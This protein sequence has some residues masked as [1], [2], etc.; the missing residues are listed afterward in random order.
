MRRLIA[1]LIFLMVFVSLAQ[2]RTYGQSNA[3]KG[4]FIKSLRARH[5]DS[6]SL[7][8]QIHEKTFQDISD[9]FQKSTST[10]LRPCEG[11]LTFL[12][13]G[14][15]HVLLDVDFMRWDAKTEAM[16]SRSNQ[17]LFKEGRLTEYIRHARHLATIAKK[18]PQISRSMYVEAIAALYFPLESPDFYSIESL[19]FSHK[20]STGIHVFHGNGI[21][22]WSN[23]QLGWAPVEIRK[24]GGGRVRIIYKLA[25]SALTEDAI[26]RLASWSAEVLGSDAKPV[27]GFE[28]EVTG[29]ELNPNLDDSSFSIQFSP[30]TVVKDQIKRANSVVMDDFSLRPYISE[31]AEAG[32]RADR[33]LPTVPTRGWSFTLPVGLFFLLICVAVAI[34][35]MRR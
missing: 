28:A 10:N 20:E 26:P 34:R 9:P 30:G 33:S 12:R 5:L 2:T 21:E 14:Q 6:L 27:I 8:A 31:Q 35:R 3:P 25:Y 11:K 4:Q 22:I 29:L 23:P 17:T 13:R 32:L 1:W 24:R 15:D 16:V 18:P 19:E 7:I